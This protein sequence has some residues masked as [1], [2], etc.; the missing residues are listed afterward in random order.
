MRSKEEDLKKVEDEQTKKEQ[1]LQNLAKQLDEWGQKLIARE[2]AINMS[3]IPNT[4]VPGKRFNKFKKIK[5]KVCGVLKLK[6]F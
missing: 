3:S 5:L 4:P 1:S 2:L 6:Y